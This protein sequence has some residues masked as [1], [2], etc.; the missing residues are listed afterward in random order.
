MNKI[1]FILS[2][3]AGIIISFVS[4]KGLIDKSVYSKN[5]KSIICQCQGQ[6][7]LTLMIVIP[8][9]FGS[10]YFYDKSDISK[11]LLAGILSYFIYTYASF[12]FGLIF[13]KYYLLYVVSTVLSVLSFVI[14]MNDILKLDLHFN[15]ASLVTGGVLAVITII[16]VLVLWLPS[17][18]MAMN[19]NENVQIIKESG[20][21]LVIQTLDLI[22]VI[23]LSAIVAYLVFTKGHTAGVWMVIVMV[24]II[25]LCA[26][27]ISMA[28]FESKGRKLLSGEI[29]TF[30]IITLLL[31][32]ELLWLLKGVE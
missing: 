1:L 22:M 2:I 26:A 24:K 14:I 9:F 31:S 4:F 10:L 20:G 28:I 13:D 7:L 25:T 15:K 29:I 11:L 6:D 32:G 12:C 19:G 3:S 17:I 23:P 16:F 21:K 30:S 5:P 27:I 8:I 18:F